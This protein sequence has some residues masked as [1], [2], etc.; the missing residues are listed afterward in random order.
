[1]ASEKPKPEKWTVHQIER[2]I[3]AYR[4]ERC[5]YATDLKSY[6]NR[7]LRAKALERVAAAVRP[8]RPS[9]TPRECFK[10]LHALRN[11]FCIENAKVKTAQNEGGSGEDEMYEPS[12][13]YYPKL[14]F[15]DTYLQPKKKR[16]SMQ[17]S[18]TRASTQSASIALVPLAPPAPPPP[19]PPPPQEN[20]KCETEESIRSLEETS[21]IDHIMEG[22]DDDQGPALQ[23]SEAP[24][25]TIIEFLSPIPID[26]STPAPTTTSTLVIRDRAEPSREEGAAC[27]TFPS[28]KRPKVSN[29]ENTSSA[30]STCTVDTVDAFITFI[31]SLIRSF[32]DEELRLEVMNSISQT[33]FD[34]K[35]IDI[36]RRNN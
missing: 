28:T 4:D 1:M 10:K 33:V 22:E 11:C 24:Q 35:S 32:Q 9:T 26:P 21:I 3:A 36:K 25:D 13:W 14:M 16:K 34:A 15:L 23:H 19:P 20:W 31:G 18:E 12:L 7:V 8:L 27:D 6:H 5:L 17:T 30:N 29:A 2:L